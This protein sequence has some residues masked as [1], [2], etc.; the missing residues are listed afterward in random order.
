MLKIET[1]RTGTAVRI[2]TLEAR[3]D[4]GEEKQT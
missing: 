2:N 3:A 1:V 4:A